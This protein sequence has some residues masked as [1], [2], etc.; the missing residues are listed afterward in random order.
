MSDIPEASA[1]NYCV[2]RS[3]V[4]I[5][6]PTYDRKI[7][8]NG[9]DRTHCEYKEK[10]FYSRHGFRR[11]GGDCHLLSIEDI[12]ASWTFVPPEVCTKWTAVTGTGFRSKSGDYSVTSDTSTRTRVQKF[13][14]RASKHV[15]L[16]DRDSVYAGRCIAECKPVQ[17]CSQPKQP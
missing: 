14:T 4:D 15:A 11:R 8:S 1:K 13:K 9:V 17:I 10:R 2:A 3:C 7:G 5:F 12:F 16:E 6:S